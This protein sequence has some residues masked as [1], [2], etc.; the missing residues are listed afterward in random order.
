MV[1]I[2]YHLITLWRTVLQ[3]WTTTAALAL[4]LQ[5]CK[6]INCINI[7]DILLPGCGL[8]IFPI[9]CHCYTPFCI[10]CHIQGHFLDL[11]ILNSDTRRNWFLKCT[12]KC[13]AEENYGIFRKDIK[14]TL[15]INSKALLIRMIETKLCAALQSTRH[16]TLSAGTGVQQRKDRQGYKLFPP[17]KG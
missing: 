8:A 17:P 5:C 3:T 11:V 7:C 4:V 12:V 6:R 13:L 15:L 16:A 2:D 9:N 10:Q 14:T 1:A